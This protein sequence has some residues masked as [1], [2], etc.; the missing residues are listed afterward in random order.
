M[1]DEIIKKYEPKEEN[2]LDI[3]H[4]IQDSDPQ[5]YLNK[6]VIKKVSKHLN[7]SLSQIYGVITFYT[8][9]SVKPRGKFIIRICQSAP[10]HLMGSK[11][12]IEHLEQLLRV[13]VGETT[14]DGVFTLET[15]SCLGVCGVAP[16][17]MINDDVY[18]NLTPERVNNIIEKMR[19]E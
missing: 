1:V 12:L 16:A 15:T 3:L 14:E 6:E 10:C 13:D 5:H 18:G 9:F 7:I 19:E 4:D 11:S 2:I 8:M 17:M